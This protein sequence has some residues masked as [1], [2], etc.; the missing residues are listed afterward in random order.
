MD[1]G[2]YG[3]GWV[4]PVRPDPNGSLPLLFGIEKIRQSI[5]IILSTAPGERQML[6][7]FGCGIHDLVFAADTAVLRGLIQAKIR[8]SLTRW[9][10]RIDLLDVTVTSYPGQTNVLYVNLAYR[11]RVN[12]AFF[13]QVY[14][15]Y[16][17]EGPG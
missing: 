3:R 12:N 8:D 16:L 2:F 14:P 1:E 4:F 13:N 6:P 10:P 5:E 9:E 17:Q 11:V 15:F 7:E